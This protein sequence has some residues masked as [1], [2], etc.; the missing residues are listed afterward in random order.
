MSLRQRLLLAVAAALFASLALGTWLTVWQAHQIVRAELTASLKTGRRSVIAA[1]QDMPPPPN[2]AALARLVAGFDGSRHVT[3][4]LIEQRVDLGTAGG[5]GAVQSHP[6]LPTVAT[7]AWFAALATPSLQP[8]EVTFPGGVI[9]VT[10]APA[11]EVG[12]RWSEARRLILLL[13]LSSALAALLCFVT[14]AWSLRPLRP[15]TDALLR[16]EHGR[17]AEPVTADGPPEI[18]HL[19]TAFNRM[20]QALTRAARENARLSAQLDLIAEEERAELARDLHDEIGP[21]LFALTA[22]AAAARIQQTDG[23]GAAALTSL[24]SLEQTAALLQTTIRDLLR[25][26]R[27]SAP[28]SSDLAGAVNDLLDFWRGIRP[29]TRFTAE[30]PAEAGTLTEPVRAALFRVAQ[31]GVSNAIRHA[32]PTEV[33]VAVT[34]QQRRAALTVQDNGSNTASQDGGRHFAGPHVAGLGLMG[35]EERLQALGGALDIQRGRGWRIT[36]WAPVTHTVVS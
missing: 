15:L 12:E 29:Q 8:A 4:E 33:H 14:A 26:L 2:H 13:A 6:A 17:E 32:N 25:R 27:D 7:P 1:L 22:W 11:S 30:I 16:L 21:L 34:V 9:R 23:D 18:M 19:A 3:A 10:A 5:Q 28:E 36:G 20:Q 35:L 24:A 31:E